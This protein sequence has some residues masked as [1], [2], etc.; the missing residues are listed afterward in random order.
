MVRVADPPCRPLLNLDPS[1]QRD[2]RIHPCRYPFSPHERDAVQATDGIPQC[3]RP[4]AKGPISIGNG[5]CSH[6]ILPPS[7]TC[8]SHGDIGAWRR[9][10]DWGLI[11]LA[12]RSVNLSGEHY[13]GLP[14]RRTAF[15]VLLLSS[16]AAVPP[17]TATT[18]PARGRCARP[19]SCSISN[20]RRGLAFRYMKHGDPRHISFQNMGDSGARVD[21]DLFVDGQLS[22]P[23]CPTRRRV[24]AW[25]RMRRSP[26]SPRGI[27]PTQDGR[28]SRTT[29]PGGGRR[30]IR[31]A[32]A[33][34]SNS[35]SNRQQSEAY[36]SRYLSLDLLQPR[37][38]ICP[39]PAETTTSS[40][41]HASPRARVPLGI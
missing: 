39:A 20:K 10:W 8:A 18:R 5:G 36:L 37:I 14:G 28:D 24:F 27:G 41:R 11:H 1:T 22:A 2:S 35:N 7:P 17:H 26:K 9:A 32:H 12:S 19:V 30:D 13:T 15:L 16:P 40:C 31:A 21:A 33:T 3:P 6:A 25:H 34:A 38:G 4:K 23:G 29:R